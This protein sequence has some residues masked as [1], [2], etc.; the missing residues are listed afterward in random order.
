MLW[1]RAGREGRELPS[2]LPPGLHPLSQLSSLPAVTKAH[3][4][5]SVSAE[6]KKNRTVW[7][8]RAER[9][10]LR[11]SCSV[12]R[13]SA[14]FRPLRP[15]PPSRDGSVPSDA[16]NIHVPFCVRSCDS[17]FYFARHLVVFS[18]VFLSPRGLPFS[19]V[20]T[21]VKCVKR[22]EVSMCVDKAA[23]FNQKPTF[24]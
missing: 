10:A 8:L 9:G 14:S 16:E 5:D 7:I 23:I 2:D 19:V 18:P 11:A 4:C 20:L 17:P 6:N 24:K 13:L 15:H 1:P 22:E 21:L 3:L 12:C